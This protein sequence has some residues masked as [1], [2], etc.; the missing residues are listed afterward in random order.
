MSYVLLGN[1][2]HCYTPVRTL[3]GLLIIHNFI[4]L[5][6]TKFRYWSARSLLGMP[7]ESYSLF[8][9]SLLFLQ[10]Y[11]ICIFPI[12][13]IIDVLYCL[14][15]YNWPFPKPYSLFILYRGNELLN[16]GNISQNKQKSLKKYANDLI[17]SY[18]VN[19]THLTSLQAGFVSLVRMRGFKASAVIQKDALWL[20]EFSKENFNGRWIGS[21]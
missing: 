5:Y 19:N 12:F 4:S 1:L 14:A 11:L 6:R 17:D 20:K 10:N 7:I 8:S 9:T 21:L 13:A 16:S 3:L 18:F 15:L 2:V